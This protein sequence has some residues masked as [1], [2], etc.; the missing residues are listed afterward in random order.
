MTWTVGQVVGSHY[1]RDRA[2]LIKG[3]V[4]RVENGLATVQFTS[5]NGHRF[6]RTFQPN[7]IEITLRPIPRRCFKWLEEHERGL[8][9]QQGAFGEFEACLGNEDWP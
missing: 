8:R 1:G 5:W 3:I 7:G 9:Q 2:I 4:L 6:E